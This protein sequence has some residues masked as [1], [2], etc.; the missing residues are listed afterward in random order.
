VDPSPQYSAERFPAQPPA[1]SALRFALNVFTAES[2]TIEAALFKFLI[3]RHDPRL[4]SSWGL[5]SIGKSKKSWERRLWN[6][7]EENHVLN[8]SEETL[9]S[10]ADSPIKWKNDVHTVQQLRSP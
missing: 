6:L 3:S 10:C 1:D 9:V 5:T 2:F 8:S 4:R 7:L